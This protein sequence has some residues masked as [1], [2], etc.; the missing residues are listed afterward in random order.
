[1]AGPFLAEAASAGSR[2][3]GAADGAGEP[4]M[5]ELAAGLAEA[6]VGPLRRQ[7]TRAL[8]A[9]G[10]EGEHGDPAARVGVAYRE[11]KGERIET[12]AG[13]AVLAAFGRGQFQALPDEA[14]L[15][16]VVDDEGHRCP[17][18]D[19]NALAGPVPKGQEYPT[20][21]QHPPA[22]SGCRCLVLPA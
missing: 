20:G 1:V 3:A 11:W 7:L 6:I 8:D 21:Q 19:D 12:V 15:H 16:W 9:A 14:P 2:F 4:D 10:E 13:D 22:H 17:D 18:C 5:A